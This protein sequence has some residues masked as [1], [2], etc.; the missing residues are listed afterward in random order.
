MNHQP[1]ETWLL[2]DQHLSPEEKRELDTH[3]RDCVHCT[4][5]AETGLALHTVHIASPAPGF[6]ARFQ[7][8]LEAQRSAERRKRVWGV[9]LFILAGLGVFTLVGA[10]LLYQIASSP[11]EWISLILSYGLFLAVSIQ[12][13]VEVGSVL[14]Q[15]APSFIPSYLWMIV[16]S[17]LA[18]TALLW[19]VS[20]WR[21]I[22]VPRGV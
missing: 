1:F 4:A 15:V 5:L 14:L 13:V 3:L 2:D 18:G 9:I 22:R 17:G 10:P 8:R 20:I 11:T 19:T 12:T 21:V 7:Q 6:T 16:V